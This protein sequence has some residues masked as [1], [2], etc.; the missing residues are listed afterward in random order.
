M[1]DLRAALAAGEIVF[2]SA[3]VSGHP[4][5]V[6]ILGWI[7]FDYVFIDTEHAATSPSGRELE[8]VVRAAYSA[9][10]PPIVRPAENLPYHINKALDCGAKAVWVPRIE[11]A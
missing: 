7:G 3:V 10:I 1:K 6:E 11:T 9:D 5:I 4:S 8:Q 2:G